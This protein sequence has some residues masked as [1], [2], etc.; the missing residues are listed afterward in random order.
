MGGMV[1]PDRGPLT[2]DADLRGSSTL[3]GRGDHSRRSQ[4][5]LVVLPHAP[6]PTVLVVPRQP[7]SRWAER[8]ASAPAARRTSPRAWRG[9]NGPALRAARHRSLCAGHAHTHL[10]AVAGRVHHNGLPCRGH[11]GD[12]PCRWEPRREA[13]DPPPRQAVR[14]PPG[15]N[16]SGHRA[17]FAIRRLVNPRIASGA[18]AAKTHGP[19]HESNELEE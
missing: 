13:A 11:G 16:R 8:P 1:D 17:Y 15:P 19:S 18:T 5:N 14:D 2:W 7:S 12:L 10:V 4:P 3:P 9:R 6:D